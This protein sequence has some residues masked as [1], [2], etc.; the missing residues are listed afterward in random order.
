MGQGG[1]EDADFGFGFDNLGLGENEPVCHFSFSCYR[2]R[3]MDELT[4][5]C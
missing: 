4:L 1:M 5:H 2:S 3:S